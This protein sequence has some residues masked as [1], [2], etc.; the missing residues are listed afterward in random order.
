M[1]KKTPKAPDYTAAAEK[2][3]ESSK[4]VTNMQTYAD[5]PDQSTPFGTEQWTPTAYKDPA[6]GQMVTRWASKTTLNPAQQA[7]LDSQNK[8]DQ[9]RSA[10]GQNL[11][12]RMQSETAQPMDWSKF[13]PEVSKVGNGGYYNKAAGDALM[14]Q[15]SDRNEPLFANE[16]NQT[17]TRL[18]NQG[19][20]P[21][22]EAYDAQMKALEQQHN[23]QRTDAATRATQLAGAE[24]SRMQ[25]EDLASGNFQNTGRQQQIAE[26]MSKR[27]FSLNEING[28]LNGQQIGMPQMPSYSNVSKADPT[29]YSGAAG[30]QYQ[31]SLDAANAKNG[32]I[33]NIANMVGNLG[34]A[35]ITASDRRLKTNIELIGVFKGQKLYTFDYVWGEKSGGVMADEVP[36]QFV[37]KKG[38]FAMVDYGRLFRG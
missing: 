7:A 33:A 14:K 37:S 34:S 32:G 22:D 16:R 3:G 17:E 12:S 23:D 21:G 11:L 5:R 25:G 35:A 18:R 28:L 26:A 2:T 38:R 15:F 36:A 13:T 1:S 6:T 30:Q 31:S 24:G 20:N 4:Q 19:L 8:I 10:T 27:G 9:T 29:N